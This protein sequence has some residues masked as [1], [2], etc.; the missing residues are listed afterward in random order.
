MVTPIR[1]GGGFELFRD[2]ATDTSRVASSS[3]SGN[4]TA[5]KATP[6]LLKGVH[7]RNTSTSDVRLKLYDQAT[8]PTLGSTASLRKVLNLPAQSAAAYDFPA[9]IAFATGLAYCLTAGSSDTDTTTPAAGAITD[10][11]LDFI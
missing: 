10:L 1:I 2:A 4:P 6:A 7:S 11:N 8:A 9:G 5:A 3:T